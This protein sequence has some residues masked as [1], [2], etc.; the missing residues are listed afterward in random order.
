MTRV[1][2]TDDVV[3]QL[4]DVLDEDVLDDEHNYMG[5]QFAA[6]DLGHEELAQFVHEAD[7]ATYHEALQQA[8][9]LDRD[10]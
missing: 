4:R 5:A 7:A 2:I 6:Q 1:P 8:K 9:A 10:G 3:E